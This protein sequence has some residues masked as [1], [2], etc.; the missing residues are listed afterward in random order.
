MNGQFPDWDLIAGFAKKSPGGVP[1]LHKP[2]TCGE[3]K[4]PPVEGLCAES[5]HCLVRFDKLISTAT[6]CVEQVQS[7][8]FEEWLPVRS[9]EQPM[10][11]AS[12]PAWLRHV[13]AAR[14][15]PS[16]RLEWLPGDTLAGVMLA[17]YVIPV[18]VAYAGLAGLPPQAGVYGY[19]LGGLG[20]AL[21]SSSRQL[22]IGPTSAI[23]P[24]DRRYRC[25]D[26]RG[27]CAALRSDRKPRSRRLRQA[28]GNG[29]AVPRKRSLR[30]CA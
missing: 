16:Y 22:A 7:A 14:W 12:V 24:N 10:K 28:A 8:P 23:S 18:S 11:Q 6:N 26:G 27:R 9:F 21:L 30:P 4:A 3:K 20:Y 2:H 13:P 5:G 1:G 15:L 19:L 25:D 17:A 29:I